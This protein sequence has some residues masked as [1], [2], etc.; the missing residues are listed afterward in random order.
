MG[1]LF[2]CHEEGEECS[3]SCDLPQGALIVQRADRHKENKLGGTCELQLSLR[4]DGQNIHSENLERSSG[5]CVL[6]TG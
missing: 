2:K 5:F 6:C 4:L 3:Q 1:V